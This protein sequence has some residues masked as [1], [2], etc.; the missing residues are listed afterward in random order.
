MH[1]AR[2]TSL[3]PT[4]NPSRAG[5]GIGYRLFRLPS[6]SGGVGGGSQ[7]GGGFH[8][9]SY[10]LTPVLDPYAS[11]VDLRETVDGWFVTTMPDLNQRNPHLMTYLIQNSKWWIETVGIDGIR[12]D[13]YPYA[14]ADGMARWMKELDD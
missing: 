12:M 3:G 8:L 11:K 4:P 10:K 13:T 2:G 7:A 6:R 5:G 14:D 9:T 1:L